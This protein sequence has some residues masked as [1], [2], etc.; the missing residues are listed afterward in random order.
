[1]KKSHGR[2]THTAWLPLAALAATTLAV[3]AIT[4]A[5]LAS[6]AERKHPPSGRFIDVD[7]VRLHVVE[8]G[9]GAAV[10]LLHG[11]GSMVEDFVLS[12][13][14]EQASSRYRV[15]AFDRPGFG[16]SLR[17]RDRVWTDRVQA[18]LIHRALVEM[19]VSTALILGHSWGC[20]VAVALAL[21][22][23]EDVSGLVLLSGYFYPSFRFDVPVMVWPAVPVI[24]DVIRYAISPTVGRLLWPLFVKRLFGPK[25]PP[26]A[27]ACFPKE[28]TFRPSQIRAGA[29][30]TALMVPDALARSSRYS[31]LR[32]PVAIVAGV[33]D[34]IVDVEKQSGRLH[35]E[36]PG[37]TFRRIKGVGH[38]VHQNAPSEVMSAIVEVHL[39]TSDSAEAA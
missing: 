16:H 22:Y 36:L 11:N 34:R 7:G 2:S 32:M 19:G 15:I 5:R 13:L 12:G 3:S 28:L 27:F 23:P 30:D 38:M 1:M 31:E 29:D 8:R 4:N 17:P 9:S 18:E 35:R 24:G 25:E 21:E 20:S 14:M 6:A 37:S 10:V 33:D 39:R 26:G